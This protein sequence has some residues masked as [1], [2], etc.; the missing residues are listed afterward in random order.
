VRLPLALA[1]QHLGG[2]VAA[3]GLYF[4]SEPQVG[5]TLCVLSNDIV[6]HLTR[7]KRFHMGFYPQIAQNVIYP[8]SNSR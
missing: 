5:D 3:G 4:R 6:L 2:N 1:L 8:V 7:H